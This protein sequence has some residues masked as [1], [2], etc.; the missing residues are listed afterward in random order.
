[1]VSDPSHRFYEAIRNPNHPQ[2]RNAIAHQ[3][4]L[5]KKAAAEQSVA[6]AGMR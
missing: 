1:M 5:S 4:M 6:G 3:S 2:Y